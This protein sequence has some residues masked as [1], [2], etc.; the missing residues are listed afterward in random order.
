MSKGT[1]RVSKQQLTIAGELIAAGHSVASAARH[2]GMSRHT[3]LRYQQKGLLPNSPKDDSPDPSAQ[4][5]LVVVT[6]A[7]ASPVLLENRESEIAKLRAELERIAYAN[8]LDFAHWDGAALTLRDSATLPRE[9]AAAIKSVTMTRDGV[10][11]QLHDKLVAITKLLQLFGVNTIEDAPGDNPKLTHN[12]Y[13]LMN[14][15]VEQTG[16]AVIP[17]ALTID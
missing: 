7:P 9:L 14:R 6:D 15:V 2:A 4:L 8:I 13:I 10:K 11:I 16:Q 1:F 17:D 5:P 3:I 12:F